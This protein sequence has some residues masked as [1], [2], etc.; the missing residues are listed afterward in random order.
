MMQINWSINDASRKRKV[1][2]M[3]PTTHSNKSLLNGGVPDGN[4]HLP[5]QGVLHGNAGRQ[6]LDALAAQAHTPALEPLDPI[7]DAH[8]IS[9][10]SPTN[11]VQRPLGSDSTDEKKPSVHSAPTQELAA[12]V[13]DPLQAPTDDAVEALLS[14]GGGGSG[15]A[16]VGPAPTS[17]LTFPAPIPSSSWLVG[18][19]VHAVG[20]SASRPFATDTIGDAGGAMRRSRGRPRAT[21]AKWKPQ[22]EPPGTRA[23]PISSSSGTAAQVPAP[24]IP[25]PGKAAFPGGTQTHLQV[26]PSSMAAPSWTSSGPPIAPEEITEVLG[27]AVD[28]LTQ[29]NAASAMKSSKPQARKLTWKPLNIK[30]M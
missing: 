21:S 27:T 7:V 4:Q 17:A 23:Q 15:F 14:I 16:V 11:N 5:A 18:M 12:E 13:V 28:S 25:A 26:A 9:S 20:F 2:H 30:C 1:A 24:V 8:H 3:G 29:A 10:A 19:N 6:A 22:W